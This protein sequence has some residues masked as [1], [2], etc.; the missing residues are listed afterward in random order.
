MAGFRHNLLLNCDFSQQQMLG[1][2][3]DSVAAVAVDQ[4]MHWFAA[5]VPTD[6]L[7]QNAK[8]AVR[9]GHRGNVRRQQDLRM[10]P[11]RVLCG[12]GFLLQDI[13]HRGT[14][15]SAGQGVE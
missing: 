5:L 11:E 12:R 4:A 8:G 3:S 6:V 15:L 10:V 14:K 13:E 9:L 2:I 7:Q 1:R